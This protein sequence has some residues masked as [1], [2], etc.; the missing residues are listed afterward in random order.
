MKII[1]HR[2]NLNGPSPSDENTFDAIEYALE[3]G[4]AVEIDIWAMGDKF[5]LGHDK[6]QTTISLGKIYE[7]SEVED[8]YVHCKNMLALQ[9]LAKLNLKDHHIFPFFHDVDDCILLTNNYVWVHPKAVHLTN[10]NYT[11]KCIAM[12]SN[13]KTLQY[14]ISKDVS[15]SL[16]HWGGIC[17]DYPESVRDNL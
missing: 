8:V 5:W 14:N 10:I 7:W 15:F 13:A 17:T 11:S 2:G 3:R 4:F 9:T 6:A 12:L 16:E 1:S